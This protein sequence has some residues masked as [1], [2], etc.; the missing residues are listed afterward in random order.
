MSH[1]W[2]TVHDESTF[3]FR[4]REFKG[5]D[6]EAGTCRCDSAHPSGPISPKHQN[7][8]SCRRTGRWSHRCSPPS[9][10]EQEEAAAPAPPVRPCLGRRYHRP[11]KLAERAAAALGQTS[12]PAPSRKPSRPEPVLLG[13]Q[14]DEGLVKEVEV[15]TRGPAVLLLSCGLVCLE[16]EPNHSIPGSVYSSLSFR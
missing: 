4:S 6:E 16:E 7:Q 1:E 11:L 14:L 8:G 10:P 15:L 9:K 12:S 2:M 13:Q 3:C 5:R